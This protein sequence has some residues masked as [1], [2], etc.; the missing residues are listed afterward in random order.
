[1]HSP[2]GEMLVSCDAWVGSRGG[3]ASGGFL[4][5]TW[6]WVGVH[7]GASGVGMGGYGPW[8]TG[9]VGGVEE[10][11]V[12]VVVFSFLGVLGWLASSS[13]CSLV[14]VPGSSRGG[15]LAGGRSSSRSGTCFYPTTGSGSW[16]G[17]R[18]GLYRL[19]TI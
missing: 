7:G 8:V 14:P 15:V 1:M 3:G 10:S 9:S 11:V 16:G 12:R 4:A 5:G 13:G 19:W 17:C 18:G 2:S 6:R